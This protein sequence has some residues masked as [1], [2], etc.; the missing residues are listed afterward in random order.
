MGR[1]WSKRNLGFRQAF[2]TNSLSF[3]TAPAWATLGLLEGTES[4]TSRKEDPRKLF[5]LSSFLNCTA[6]GHKGVGVGDSSIVWL[7]GWAVN[8]D[9][10]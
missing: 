10:D 6:S 2:L 8:E 7:A 4:F 3:F 5:S 9:L 1:V